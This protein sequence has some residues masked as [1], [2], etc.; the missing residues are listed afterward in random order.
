MSE[1]TSPTGFVAPDPARLAGLFPGY[2]IS[3]LIACGG[4]G[5]VYEAVQRSLDRTVAI[6]ILPQ[7]FTADE[8]FRDGFQAEAKAMARLNH[9]NL[10][11]VYD[12]GE[13]EGMLFI[14]MEYVPGQSLFQAAGSQSVDPY[15]VARLLAAISRGLAHAHENGIIHR[16][17]KPA[18][19]LLDTQ[20]QPKIG[21]F[22]LARPL[23][24]K[25]QEG[26][27]IFGTPGYTAPEVLQNPQSIDHR[28]DIFS[29][30]VM[31]H[32]LL[33]AKLPTDDP[34]PPSAICH[35]DPRFDAVVRKATQPSPGSRYSSANEIAAELDAIASAA[36]RRVLQ[37]A[38]GATRRPPVTPK[39]QPVASSSSNAP[40]IIGLV[41]AIAVVGGL[42]LFLKKPEPP[43]VTDVEQVVETLPVIPD[44]NDNPEVVAVVPPVDPTPRDLEPD[45]TDDFDNTVPEPDP[46]AHVEVDL[47]DGTRVINW[48]G[49]TSEWTPRNDGFSD[50][51]VFADDIWAARD[52][53]AFRY[54]KW[55][56]D[57]E[58]I[59]QMSDLS[60][61]YQWAKAGL[62]VRESLDDNARHLFLARTP[63]QGTA[64]LVR[65]AHGGN[66]AIQGQ[67]RRDMPYLRI[68]RSGSQLDASVSMDGLNWESVGNTVTIFDL[69]DEVFVGVAICSHN[70]HDSRPLK[71]TVSPLAARSAAAGSSNEVEEFF[72]R[73]RGIMLDRCRRSIEDHETALA[74]NVQ[75]FERNFRRINRRLSDRFRGRADLRLQRLL[76][77]IGEN[78]NRIP[79]NIGEELALVPGA[80][81]V[82]EEAL[83]SQ[84][85]ADDRLIAAMA[86]QNDVYII[87][88]ERQVE[89]F[90]EE[91][92]LI[93]ANLVRVEISRARE[94]PHHL[95]RLMMEN[96]PVEEPD[97]DDRGWGR[98]R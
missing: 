46:V 97:D 66:T 5:A 91:N 71:G 10:I 94:S 13:V 32:E 85:E 51:E 34:R 47:P 37:T 79:E 17:I 18:N 24:R 11:G 80:D 86:E 95:G 45:M 81:G 83:A 48:G 26:E 15:E 25:I 93:G 7:E 31:L 74:A 65:A 58:F 77:E 69:A 21:D 78:A 2:Q 59:I 40:V 28:A 20:M 76:A 98:N 3:R 88:L 72:E 60:N 67:T 22:G 30:G 29:L 52:N 84:K 1:S 12:F 57:G 73:A 96:Y 23:E 8:S 33:T 87:G 38:A 43:A 14:I 6:K 53:A 4:M 39:Y 56:G 36:G 41:I 27:D 92:N 44:S 19:I 90:D 9:P 82:H 50:F 16:D 75:T 55:S 54:T 70:R 64:L 63:S 89:R 35:C 42:I 68:K 49:A 62:M 61:A